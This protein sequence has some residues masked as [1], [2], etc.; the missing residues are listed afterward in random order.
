MIYHLLPMA[1]SV[2]QA[3]SYSTHWAQCPGVT[4]R[5]LSY[6]SPE[7]VEKLEQQSRKDR[8]ENSTS[9]PRSSTRHSPSLVNFFRQ[10]DQLHRTLKALKSDPP[11]WVIGFKPHIQALLDR[12]QDPQL[13]ALGLRKLQTDTINQIASTCTNYN[14]ETI[15][16]IEPTFAKDIDLP[17]LELL[18]YKNKIKTVLKSSPIQSALK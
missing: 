10:S 8:E 7:E 1:L 4:T 14:S 13:N 3:Q 16:R 18:I 11:A 5:I 6:L 15:N 17:V 9:T 12:C 2:T